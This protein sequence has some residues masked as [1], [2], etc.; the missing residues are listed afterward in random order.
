MK[1]A[2]LV[3]SVAR[4]QSHFNLPVRTFANARLTKIVATIGPVSEDAVTLPL[5]VKAGMGVMRV[6][7]SHATDE[8]VKLR[9]SSLK[10]SN[11]AFPLDD[12]QYLNRAVLLDTK[13]PEIRTGGLQAVTTT[14]DVKAKISLVKGNEIVLTADETRKDN[15]DEKVLYINYDSLAKTVSVGKTVLLDDG[16]IAL[17]VKSV[18]KQGDVLCNVEND[19]EIAS[20]RGVNLPGM[21]VSTSQS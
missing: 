8:E 14:G 15:G 19:G 7:F 9:L 21:R 11:G 2:A 16:A 6:N 4:S 10:K 20:R 3:R 13:G 17:T 12:E 18:N 1:V 5:V